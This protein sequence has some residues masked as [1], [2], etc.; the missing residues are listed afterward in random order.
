LILVVGTAHPTKDIASMRFVR[1]KNVGVVNGRL[2]PCPG[3]PNCVCSFDADG[4][5]GI[6]PLKFAGPWEAARDRLLSV[7]RSQPRTQVV[8]DDGPY[9]RIECTSLI[10]RF[11]D[12]LEFLFDQTTQVIHVRS[13]SRVGR[14]DLG[15]N[16]NR[17]EAIR[18][19]FEQA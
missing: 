16:R 1:P 10:L 4:E 14:S 12:D 18:R 13:A 11:V 3:T 19:L 2:Q 5:H 9:L 15:V 8:V 6:A 7:V 17:V